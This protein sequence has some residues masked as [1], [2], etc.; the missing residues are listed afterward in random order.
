MS[1]NNGRIL[2]FKNSVTINA[3]KKPLDVEEFRGFV[4]TDDYAPCIF[5]NGA[6]SKNANIFTLAPPYTNTRSAKELNIDHRC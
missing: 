3:T 2:I 6:D 4:T 1:F 5:I